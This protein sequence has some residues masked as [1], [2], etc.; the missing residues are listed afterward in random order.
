MAN[1]QDIKRAHK[2]T[3]LGSDSL[4]FEIHTEWHERRLLR[5][6]ND[7]NL[8]VYTYSFISP[9]PRPREVF[10][11]DYDNRICDHFVDEDLRPLLEARMTERTFN[12]RILFRARQKIQEFSHCIRPDKIPALL[13]SMN[14]YIGQCKNVNGYGELRNL[15]DCLDPRWLQYVHYNPKRKCM[16]ANPGYTFRE[17]QDRKFDIHHKPKH[18]DKTR[19][20]AAAA[21]A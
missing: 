1:L 7:R 10:A 14:S 15:V 18:H 2:L 19:K 17:M 20:R 16:Q 3:P 6:I 13:A 12:N 9:R 21:S 8:L 4:D 11:C 5:K